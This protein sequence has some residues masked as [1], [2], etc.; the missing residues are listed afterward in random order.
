MLN[1]EAKQ[2]FSNIF[3]RRNL[4]RQKKS[5][6]IYYVVAA[7]ILAAVAFVVVHEVPMEVETVE[8]VLN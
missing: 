6:W 5:N 7:L 3:F 4:M 2:N 1:I 8:T